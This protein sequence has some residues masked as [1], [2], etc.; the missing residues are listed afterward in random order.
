MTR[1]TRAMALKTGGTAEDDLLTKAGGTTPAPLD[2]TNPK[3]V[4]QELE[5][6]KAKIDGLE[7]TIDRLPDGSAIPAEVTELKASIDTIDAAVKEIQQGDWGGLIG[8]M[9]TRIDALATAMEPAAGTGDDVPKGFAESLLE[10]EDFK[11][12]LE[13]PEAER[14]KIARL[15]ALNSSRSITV[16][17]VTWPARFK[18]VTLAD[19]GA[20]RPPAYRPGI[21][22]DPELP[23]DLISR[24]P[25]VVADGAANWNVPYETDDGIASYITTNASA[26][27][28][29]GTTPVSAIPVDSVAGFTVGSIARIITTGGTY[30]ETVTGIDEPNSELDFGTDEIDFDIAEGDRVIATFFGATGELETK[31][32]S[33]AELD[34]RTWN[35]LTMALLMPM[36]QQVIN[37]VSGIESWGQMKLRMRMSR[38]YSQHLLYGDNA[39]YSD[40]L[41]GLA[42]YPNAQTF[43]WSTDGSTG[44]NRADAIVRA[45]DLIRWPGPVT[46][47]MSRGDITSLNLEKTSTEAYVHSTLF[48]RLP[49]VN[50]GGSWFLGPW[51]LYEDDA[52]TPGDFF[53]I[54]FAAASEIVDQ[55]RT[56]MTAGMIDKDFAQNIIRWRYEEVVLHAILSTAAYVVGE[57]DSA[58][59]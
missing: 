21:V 48:G 6:L 35:F 30:E 29:G 39:S 10:A 57:W 22:S 34:L 42:T 9:K 19:V 43:T 55:N 46:V 50:V 25:R 7:S 38:N 15:P 17:S 24:I 23:R 26:A 47:V 2:T 44:D 32:D 37:T 16:P 36:S 4:E 31:P 28:A 1:D 27:V 49:L 45:I 56:T 8:A 13:N 33:G 58:P 40:Q 18:T 12:L 11:A 41:Q 14:V 51:E 52:V 59:A 20:V 53:P 54:N 3:R 5:G